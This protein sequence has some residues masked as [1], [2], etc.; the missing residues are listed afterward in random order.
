M[1][2]NVD[3]AGPGKE[4][5]GVESLVEAFVLIRVLDVGNFVAVKGEVYRARDLTRGDEGGSVNCGAHGVY[6]FPA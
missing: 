4:A 6:F 2:M 1:G 3:E 5:V